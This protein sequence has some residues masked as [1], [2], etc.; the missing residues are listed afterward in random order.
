MKNTH[1]HLLLAVSFSSLLA[2]YSASAAIKIDTV[3][4]GDA[5]NAGEVQSQGTFG[6]VSYD[7]HI[8]TYEVTNSQYTAFL[9]ATAASDPNGLYNTAMGSSAFFR[10]GISRSGSS[11]S[12]S[13]STKTDMGNKPVGYVSF[14][15]AARF[16]NWLT[17]GQPTGAQ[18]SGTTEDG[19]YNLAAPLDPSTVVR[20]RDFS[21]GQN[22]VAITS[23]NEWYKAAYYDGNGGYFDYA[24][25]S[26]A[27]PTIATADATGAVSNP[28][29]NVANY[30][31]GA[32]WNGQ[33]GNL[34][35]VGSAGANSSSHYGTFDQ[36]GNVKEMFDDILST[37]FRG[38]R[39]GSYSVG[40]G[41][42]LSSVRETYN[43]YDESASS[44]FRVS[45]LTPIPEPSAYAAIL[46]CL[47]LGLALLRRR[48]RA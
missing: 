39:G 44:G 33:N 16:A 28:G 31:L 20:Q 22:G 3:R 6:A 48:G 1:H 21:L 36:S 35:T 34:T 30:N 26:N 11:G 38:L 10:G 32:D 43:P 42:L 46:G 18:G 40:S 29:I 9:N 14:W 12:Y 25:Q 41:S 27:V 7:Y 47:G 15:D 5:G 17:N 4:V 24:T 8:G 37:S 19:M 23:E 13:Y 45:S 2:A